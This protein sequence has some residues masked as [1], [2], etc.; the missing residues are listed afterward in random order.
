MAAALL[1]LALAIALFT[2]APPA[3]AWLG[4]VLGWWFFAGLPAVGFGFASCGHAKRHR[5]RRTVVV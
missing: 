3:L 4:S 5:G 2:L 1:P